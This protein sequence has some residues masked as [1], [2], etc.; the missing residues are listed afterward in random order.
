VLD[1]FIED[2]PGNAT[3]LIGRAEVNLSARRLA[4]AEA[5][6]RLALSRTVALQAGIPYSFKTGLAWFA[7]ARILT[8]LN[9]AAS[10]RTA[11]EHA[12]EHL[13]ATVDSE[14]PALRSARQLM[15]TS[16]SST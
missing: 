7:L 4:E 13:T 2:H 15:Q 5:D 16:G 9:E 14:H 1:K 6:A 12:V 8:A 3:A 11:L 10:A